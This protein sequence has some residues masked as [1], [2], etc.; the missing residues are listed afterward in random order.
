MGY[1]LGCFV[2]VRSD[3][4]CLLCGVL[5]VLSIVIIA[6]F[7]FALTGHYLDFIFVSTTAFS[8]YLWGLFA[9]LSCVTPKL[10]FGSCYGV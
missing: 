7:L 1:L 9:G 8:G 5:A 10:G 2:I 4:T 3:L 6:L